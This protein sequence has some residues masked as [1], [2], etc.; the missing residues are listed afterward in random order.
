M[1]VGALT[2]I[3]TIRVLKRDQA[4]LNLIPSAKSQIEDE[5]QS[6]SR[7]SSYIHIYTITQYLRSQSES[8]HLYFENQHG[9]TEIPELNWI[10]LV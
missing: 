4:L 6:A 8:V 3:S 9:E 7:Q 1:G 10:E 2:C 5:D